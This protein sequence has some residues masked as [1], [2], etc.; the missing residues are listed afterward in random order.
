M[1]SDKIKSLEINKIHYALNS[2]SF[3]QC[4]PKRDRFAFTNSGAGTFVSFGLFRKDIRT[5]EVS[6]FLQGIGFTEEDIFT[7]SNILIKSIFSKKNKMFLEKCNG[8]LKEN[9]VNIDKYHKDLLAK[10]IIRISRLGGLGFTRQ[11][12]IVAGLTLWD[13]LSERIEEGGTFSRTWNNICQTKASQKEEFLA[14]YLHRKIFNKANA[15]E[16]TKLYG[17]MLA[18]ILE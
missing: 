11:S 14:H 5:S 10:E 1:A 17:I 2:V 9:K 8:K 12:P 15:K 18:T 4:S 16:T 6:T 13:N 3:R 7:I